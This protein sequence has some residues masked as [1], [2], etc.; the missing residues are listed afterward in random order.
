[1]EKKTRNIAINNAKTHKQE[2]ANIFI[3]FMNYGFLIWKLMVT[4]NLGIIIRDYVSQG[5][6]S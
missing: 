2:K 3:L 6:I 4:K 5:L 1:M